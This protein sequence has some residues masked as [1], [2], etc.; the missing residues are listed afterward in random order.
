MDQP[1]LWSPNPAQNSIKKKPGCWREKLLFQNGIWVNLPWIPWGFPITLFRFWRNSFLPGAK[2]QRSWRARDGPVPAR[3]HQN[4]QGSISPHL[5]VQLSSLSS[6]STPQGPTIILNLL[7]HPSQSIH[8]PYLPSW[9]CPKFPCPGQPGGQEQV[10]VPWAPAMNTSLSVASQFHGTS[11][12]TRVPPPA[13]SSPRSHLPRWGSLLL[14]VSVK[15]FMKVWIHSRAQKTQIEMHPSC[16]W[17]QEYD[18]EQL[19]L[20][21]DFKKMKTSGLAWRGA[22]KSILESK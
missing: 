1:L 9:N 13:Q 15:Q 5:R 21:I 10:Q 2:A 8:H 12:V 4:M 19:P 6:S 3:P 11:A 18:S 17:C 22:T 7:H 14:P 16:C 20:F